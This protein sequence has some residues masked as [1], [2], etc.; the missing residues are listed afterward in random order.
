MSLAQL[1]TLLGQ[2]D[3]HYK[4]T[5]EKWLR[6]LLVRHLVNKSPDPAVGGR[7]ENMKDGDSV[8]VRLRQLI[9]QVTK[10]GLRDKLRHHEGRDKNGNMKDGDNV[11]DHSIS[12]HEATSEKLGPPNPESRVSSPVP[13]R[14][15]QDPAPSFHKVNIPAL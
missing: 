6:E 4:V 3:Q 5:L 7:N 13:G 2:L 8:D 11:G 1:E 14:P 10:S 9:S 12:P 15:L